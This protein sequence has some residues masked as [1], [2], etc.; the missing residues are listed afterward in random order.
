[1]SEKDSTTFR[2]NLLAFRHKFVTMA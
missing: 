2:Q 1:M